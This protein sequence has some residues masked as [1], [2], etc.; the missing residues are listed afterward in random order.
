[1]DIDQALPSFI[2]ESRE[3]LEAMNAGLLGFEHTQDRA[4][5]VN[6]IFRAAHTIKGSASLFG[7]DHI[8]AFTHVLESVLDEAREGSVKISGEMV[9]LLLSCADHIGEL[10][11]AAE[12]GQ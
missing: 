5:S 11:D 1:M 4:E 3:L 2:V 8:V 12:R 7:L 10:I 6:A 9:T